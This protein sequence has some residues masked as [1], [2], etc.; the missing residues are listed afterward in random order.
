MD[1]A[2][3]SAGVPV[4]RRPWWARW[5]VIL[6]IP[7]ASVAFAVGVS[8]LLTNPV[9]AVDAQGVATISGQFQ[10]YPCTPGSNACVQ[11][12]VQAGGRGVFVRLPSGC[13]VPTSGSKITV[14]GK[15]APDLGKAAYR[16][17]GCAHG[18]A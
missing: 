5:V 1:V 3:S 11:G 10:Q 9:R 6:A 13:P 14:Q 12:Y 8:G 18:A 4:I 2:I 15:P 17:V 7:V 16:S